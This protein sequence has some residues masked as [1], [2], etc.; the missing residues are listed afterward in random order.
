MEIFHDVGV[1]EDIYRRSPPEER[2][3]RVAWYTSLGGEGV[4]RRTKIGQLSAWGGGTSRERYALAS[5]RPFA[6]LPQVRLDTLLWQH[7]D[8]RSPGRI[9]ARQEVVDLAPR[10]RRHRYHD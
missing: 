7:A 3:H 5:P 1:A 4:G 2:W 8:A 10:R 9:R 6:N